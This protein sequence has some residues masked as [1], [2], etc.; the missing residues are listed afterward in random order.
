MP[1][2]LSD[3]RLARSLARQAWIQSCND[4]ETAD[5]LFRGSSKLVGLDPATIFLLIQ[6]AIKL[7]KWWAES[8]HDH[9]SA[10]ACLAELQLM[11]ISEDDE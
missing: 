1:L 10:V 2:S 11:E 6:I 7:W 4:I 9:P 3:R 8:R 5:V